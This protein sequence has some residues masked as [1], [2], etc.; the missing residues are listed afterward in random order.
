MSSINIKDLETAQDVNNDDF[1][2]VEQYNGTKKVKARVFGNIDNQ[3]VV[4]ARGDNIDLKER[5]KNFD[6]HLSDT[7]SKIQDLNINVKSIGFLAFGN[8]KDDDTIAIQKAIDL[9]FAN[10]GGT[11]YFP[12]GKYRINGTLNIKSNVFLEGVKGSSILDFSQREEFSSN[13]NNYLISSFGE[14]KPPINLISDGMEKSFELKLETSSFKEGD[15]I[16]I[17]SNDKWEETNSP[18]YCNIGELA[19]VTNII[20]N[21]RLQL[22]NSLLDTYKVSSDAKVHKIEPVKNVCVKGLT[23]IG[24]GRNPN[25]VLDADFGLGFT[26]CE[27]VTVR[28][29][30]F[31]Y[32]DTV[33]LEFRSCYKFTVDN[34][35]FKHGKYTTLDSNGDVIV[36]SPPVAP[37]T[38][39]AVQYQVRTSDACMYGNIV[40]CVGIGGRHFFNTGHSNTKRDG[41]NSNSRNYLFG[42]NRFITINNCKSTGTWHANYSTHND[43]EYV[44]FEDCMANSSG[45]IGFNP[46]SNKNTIRNCNAINCETG[47]YLS[48]NIRDVDIYNNRITN[49]RNGIT[50]TSNNNLDFKRIN[51]D[52]NYIQDGSY[53]IVFNSNTS[54]AQSGTVSITDNK[55]LNCSGTGIEFNFLQ[56]RFFVKNNSIR[57]CGGTALNIKNIMSCLLDSNF[58]SFANRVILVSNATTIIAY[59]NNAFRCK[60]GIKWDDIYKAESAFGNNNTYSNADSTAF[61]VDS[62]I[63][64]G[65]TSGRPATGLTTGYIYFDTSIRKIICWDGTK[66][67]DSNGISV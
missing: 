34:C 11:V 47:I 5:L 22:S 38:R 53:G 8:G 2:L 37:A 61:V 21:D 48:D 20:S 55:V 43:A 59:N 62:K 51:I 12:P 15:L 46:R 50:F 10:G 4:E 26:Y 17:K 56:G 14:I 23:L 41:S 29:C 7:M 58:V 9:A 24:K 19:I 64:S 49:C 54:A 27:N 36:P 39:G 60:T 40:N 63:R 1:L 30:S 44:V 6:L 45:T 32:I 3:E 52:S 57:D 42:V 28:D 33:Q 65:A 16:L 13:T 35:Y 66:W 18:I 67:I 31:E 25:P